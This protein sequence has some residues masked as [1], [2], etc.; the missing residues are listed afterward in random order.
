MASQYFPHIFEKNQLPGFRDV[1]GAKAREVHAT[2]ESLAI[3]PRGMTPRIP[4]L[5]DECGH[6][7][8]EKAV[9]LLSSIC[10]GL[11]MTH[12]QANSWFAPDS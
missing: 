1:P 5:V 11:F 9:S 2:R 10:G 3:E 8:P 7:L 12:L 4:L 6:E